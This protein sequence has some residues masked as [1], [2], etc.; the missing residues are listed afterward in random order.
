METNEENIS[1]NIKALRVK[2]GL[3]QEQAASLLNVSKPTYLNIEK[4][5]LGVPINKLLQ[6]AECLQCSL[7]EFFLPSQFT[8]SEK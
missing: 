5:P 3:N 4:H 7:N 2:R 1:R 6:V 8:E